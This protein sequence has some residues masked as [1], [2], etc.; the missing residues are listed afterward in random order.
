MASRPAILGW[1]LFDWACQPFFTLVTTFVFAPYFAASLAPDPVTGQSLWGYATAAAGFA[2]AILSPVLGS[3]ADAT[4]PKKPWIAA[5]G[6]VLFLASFALWYA[7][8]GQANA[9]LIALFGFAFATVAVEVAAV[10]NNAMIP[11]LVPPERFGRLSGT[12]WAIG[13]LGGLVSLVIV[14]GF[15]AAD[16]GSGRTFFGIT[17]LFGLDPTQREGDRIT[18]PFSA[19]WFLI[20]VMPL[21]LFT[22]DAARSKLKLGEAVRQGVAQ[23]KHT[24][25]DA[26]RHQG[27]LRFLIANMVYQDAL[28]ALFA[29]G[30]IYGAGVFGWQATE[31]GLFGI[32]LT[33]TGTVG[34]LIGGRLD[35]RFGAKPVILGAIFVL[36]LVCVGVLSLGRDH[37]L[38]VIPTAPAAEGLYASTPEK[39]FV[40]LGLIIG[41]VAG[42]LQAS[43]RSLLARLVP[44]REAGRYFGLLALSGKVTS[45]LAPLAVAIATA[46][47]ETQAAG[48]AVLILFLF[49]GF[50]ILSGVRKA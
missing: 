33:I 21:F 23:V 11:H 40:L 41:S 32:M 16:A 24:L 10:F 9:I 12:G 28:V 31:L 1:L 22:P 30:G 44:A 43:S 3:V 25:S 18:G 7:A 20:F 46:I 13:Y 5:C 45:F 27:V 35:D 17:P 19:V 48:P 38:F 36:A 6:L 39:L 8:P 15:L 42:P 4:G 47:F 37:I 34:A 26:R 14:L 29:F 50:M 2:L 49:A